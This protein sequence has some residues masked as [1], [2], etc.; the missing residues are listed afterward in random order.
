MTYL[1]GKLSEEIK[2]MC[3]AAQQLRGRKLTEH[4]PINAGKA[5]PTPSRKANQSSDVLECY[6]DVF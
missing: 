5:L 1:Q 4:T 3:T 6:H 2:G